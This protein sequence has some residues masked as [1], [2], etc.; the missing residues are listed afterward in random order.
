MKLGIAE[1]VEQTSKLNSKQDQVNFLRKN[2]SVPLRIVLKN[3]LDPE[4]KFALPEG[5]PPFKTSELP[6]SHG[7]LYSEARRLYLFIE[8]GNLNLSKLKRETLFI[9]ILE[10]VDPKDA[11][12]LVHMKDKKLPYNVSYDTVEE[13]FPGL[14]P[15]RTQFPQV[16]TQ[17]VESKPKRKAAAKKTTKPKAKAPKKGKKKVTKK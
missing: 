16:E 17:A 15:P 2:D 5:D 13:A 12:L 11:K 7:M 8:G 6:D 1:I 10:A 14:I 4:I 9:Q 3:A